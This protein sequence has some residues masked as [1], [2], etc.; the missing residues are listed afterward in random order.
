MNHGWHPSS[1]AH[2][3]VSGIT[4]EREPNLLSMPCTMEFKVTLAQW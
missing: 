2:T 3:A 1:D 4:P